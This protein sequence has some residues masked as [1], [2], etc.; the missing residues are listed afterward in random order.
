MDVEHEFICA[1]AWWLT[2]P[3]ESLVYTDVYD[4]YV[5]RWGV[6]RDHDEHGGEA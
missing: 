5:V 6:W 1:P 4:D 2:H 3:E